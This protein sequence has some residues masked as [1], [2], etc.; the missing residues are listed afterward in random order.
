MLVSAGQALNAGDDDG[1]SALLDSV[2]TALDAGSL[3]ASPQAAEELAVV[4]QVL[5][6]GY[7]PQHITLDQD[8]ATVQAVSQSGGPK[9]DQLTLRRGAGGWQVLASGWLDS[10]LRFGR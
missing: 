1:A 10:W 7:E 5:A 9:L 8:A 6:A 2:N 3:A 4:Q